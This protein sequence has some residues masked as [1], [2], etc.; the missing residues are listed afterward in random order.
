[1]VGGRRNRACCRRRATVSEWDMLVAN[2]ARSE[3]LHHV[4]AVCLSTSP[5]SSPLVK[6]YCF[7]TSGQP[8][9]DGLF[10]CEDN[11][12]HVFTP[13]DNTAAIHPVIELVFEN[14][15]HA[16]HEG[17]ILGAKDGGQGVPASMMALLWGPD[18]DEL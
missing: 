12:Q 17:I 10:Y 4:K 9:A 14:L 18:F 5:L 3:D 6:L 2:A 16:E 11:M 15:G 13:F 7:N 1:M 8:L